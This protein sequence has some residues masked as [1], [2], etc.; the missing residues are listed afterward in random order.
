M[1][2][3]TRS[4]HRI[5]DLRRVQGLTLDA[6]AERCGASRSNISLIERAPSSPTATVLDKLP[7]GLG[8][9][10]ASLFETPRDPAA[11][12]S[13]RALVTEQPL[14]TD[15]ASGCVR[16]NVSPSDCS[17]I[18]LVDP[19]FRPARERPTTTACA[20]PTCSSRSE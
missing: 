9:T 13:P 11:R 4:G 16:R 6:L 10:V 18:Q 5:H 1:D 7:A 20:R 14:W 19:L 12:P 3:N 17:P 8:G 2:T 15:P